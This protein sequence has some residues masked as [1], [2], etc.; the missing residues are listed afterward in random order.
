MCT[1]DFESQTNLTCNLAYD[2]TL[3]HGHG[4]HLLFSNVELKNI[5]VENYTWS[6]LIASS[7]PPI[8]TSSVWKPLL[9]AARLSIFAQS[10]IPQTSSLAS[11]Y[12]A[13]TYIS[14]TH[15]DQNYL[16]TKMVKLAFT[17]TVFLFFVALSYARI[18]I[19]RPENEVTFKDL[20]I[21]LLEDVPKTTTTAANSILLPSEK[22]ETELEAVVKTKSE[23]LE[24]NTNGYTPFTVI[25]LHPINRH[26]HGRPSVIFRHRRPCRHQ[27]MQKPWGSAW[28]QNREV[29]YGNDMLMSSGNN[30]FVRRIPARWARFHHGDRPRVSLWRDDDVASREEFK[31]PHPLHHLRHRH[32]HHRHDEVEENETEGEKHEGGFM[33]KIR[34]FLNRF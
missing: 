13:D 11:I 12:T 33:M 5:G 34:K 14:L 30:N 17:V 24:S 7:L 29:R 22:S 15:L 18:P 28:S 1:N 6:K 9:P 25:D 32:H 27:H 3:Q 4:S 31:R 8:T 2:C 21:D 19:D 16:P 20:A 26:F 23:K 10:N